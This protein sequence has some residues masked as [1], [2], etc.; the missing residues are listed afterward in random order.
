MRSYR[1]IRAA[2]L[3]AIATGLV[4]TACTGTAGPLFSDEIANGG[5]ACVGSTCD[6]P[7][8]DPALASGGW[9]SIGKTPLAGGV[10]P[11]GPGAVSGSLSTDPTVEQ[12]G[13]SPEVLAQ[14]VPVLVEGLRTPWDPNNP[15][16]GVIA[17]GVY[18]GAMRPGV[19]DLFAPLPLGGWKWVDDLYS[20]PVRIETIEKVSDF[21]QA[22]ITLSAD[23]PLINLADGSRAVMP[24]QRT[25]E[26]TLMEDW[27]LDWN[28]SSDT[29]GRLVPVKTP[30]A[31]QIHGSGGGSIG[32]TETA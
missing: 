17:G 18:G 19:N 30:P 5:S 25:V 14:F 15:R 3:T 28:R 26:V 27:I 1:T 20:A 22:R 2:T 23:L 8:I 11:L 9:A 13:L 24:V 7:L 29:L 10:V 6:A 4:L 31:L 12:D 16:V 32:D 21:P